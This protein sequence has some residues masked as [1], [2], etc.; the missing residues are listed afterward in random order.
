MCVP[1]LEGTLASV[2]AVVTCL[3][4][5][6]LVDAELDI[7]SPLISTV[8]PSS[9][10]A[11]SFSIVVVTLLVVSADVFVETSDETSDVSAGSFEVPRMTTSRVV[12]VKSIL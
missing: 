5:T 8:I 11:V 12:P 2:D 10:S 6:F 4:V 7:S 3:V 9:G 1:T